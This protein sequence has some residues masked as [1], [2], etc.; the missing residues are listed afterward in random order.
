[1]IGPRYRSGGQWAVW[2]ALFAGV[3]EDGYPQP[4]WDPW[5]G[6]IH[7]DAA[8]RAIE[9]YDLVRRLQENWSTLGPKLEGKTQRADRQTR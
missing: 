4:L 1:M 3:A 6:E 5:T 9:N 8:N 7:R 2:N